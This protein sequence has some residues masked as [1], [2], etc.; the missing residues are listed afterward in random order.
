ME[1][2]KAEIKYN[3]NLAK[4][5]IRELEWLIHPMSGQL[6]KDVEKNVRKAVTRLKKELQ[7]VER[8]LDKDEKSDKLYLC[9]TKD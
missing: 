5:H 2:S 8:S 4:K 3:L 7:D 9:S 1:Y 6:G